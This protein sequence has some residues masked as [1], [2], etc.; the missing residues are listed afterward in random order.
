[1]WEAAPAPMQVSLQRHDDLVRKAIESNG[2]TVFKT[3]GD[4]FCAAFNDPL[5]AVQ[6]ALDAQLVL[7]V[8]P[9][10]PDTPVKVRMAIHTGFAEFRH[11][12]YFGQPLNRAARLMAAGHGGQVLLSGVTQKL[13]LD[14]L[15]SGVGLRDLG[16]HLLRDLQRPETIYQLLHSELQEEFPPLTSLSNPALPNNLPQQVSSFIGREREIAEVKGL[17]LSTRLLTLTGMGGSGKTRLSLQV[18]ADLLETY[19]DGAWLVE[20]AA[21]SDPELVPQ[22]VAS[23]LGL[24]EE[25]ELP[26]IQR[27]TV[28]LK[29]K[30]ILL[31]LDNCEHLLDACAHL[32]DTLLRTCPDL[33]ILATSREPLNIPGEQVLHVPP[34]TMPDRKPPLPLEQLMQYEAIRLFV[35]RAQQVNPDF[36]VDSLNAVTLVEV[37]VQLD[38]IPLA[39]ELAAARMRVL[40]LEELHTRLSDRFRLLT[41]GSRVALPRQQTLRALI[42]WSYD[43]LDEPERVLLRRLPVFAGG[44]TLHAAEVVCSGIPPSQSASTGK[45]VSE[46][47]SELEDW[48]ILDLLSSLVEKSLVLFEEKRGRGRYRMLETVRQY[49]MERLQES[50]E[51]DW[52]HSRHSDYYLALAE[53]AEPQLLGAQQHEWLE[54]L[55]TEL[56]NFRAAFEWCGCN[57]ET[58]AK[59]LR[60]AGAF[61]R[62]WYMRGYVKEGQTIMER[63][64]ENQGDISATGEYLTARA[65][66]LNAAGMLWTMTGDY[67]R[68]RDFYT[69]SLELRRRLGDPKQVAGSLNNLGYVAHEQGDYEAAQ[70]YLEESL[71]LYREMGDKWSIATVLNNLGRIPGD[72]GDYETARTLYTES[73]QIRRELKDQHGISMS[74][75]NLGLIAMAQGKLSEA[76]NYFEESLQIRRELN[77]PYSTGIS[78]TNLG[79]ATLLRGDFEQA[80]A[81]LQEAL[82]ILRP[83]DNKH[84]IVENLEAFA[85]LAGASGDYE[86][87]AILLSAT[88]AMRERLG[89]PLPPSDNARHERER[90]RARTGLGEEAFL[91]ACERG[92]QLSFEQVIAYAM[93]TTF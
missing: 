78:L 3:L 71:A 38:G 25:Q 22:V 24:R 56:D 15:P 67:E 13:V 9:W 49:A 33:Q 62:F 65:R 59:K 87:A 82:T 80:R 64:L 92:M 5:H 41:G 7:Q 57:D 19:R 53:E 35:E 89:A 6:A 11:G 16:E 26:V 88:T 8:E 45:S 23:V 75:N 37:C 1:M 27:L 85:S 4:A 63:V 48:Q 79:Q 21:L 10:H 12:D 66:A 61:C 54:R 50:G 47:Q 44:W 51:T 90:E 34:L 42:D 70:T 83:E 32:V 73:I 36:Q 17:L 93:E 2:G 52:L 40:R 76:V 60:L 14:R 31:I 18:A 39:I 74:L 84:L 43:L 29:S 55:H 69:G 28:T 86:Q 58:G 30:Q 72:K 68:A 20:L 91:S 81:Y 46:Y 77:D